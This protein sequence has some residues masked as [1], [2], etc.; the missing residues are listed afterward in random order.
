[1][2]PYASQ[3][4]VCMNHVFGCMRVFVPVQEQLL[5][6]EETEKQRVLAT[7]SKSRFDLNNL[8][9]E[10]RRLVCTAV[11]WHDFVGACSC[12]MV[13]RN[14]GLERVQKRA[15]ADPEKNIEA[16]IIKVLMTNFQVL[17]LAA[18]FK[19]SWP[20]WLLVSTRPQWTILSDLCECSR[21]SC[22]CVP[23]STC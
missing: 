6:V 7:K 11:V 8:K 17:G 15:V 22:R 2:K 12:L 21:A 10:H 9:I 23:A 1:M 14:S 3:K 16:A 19:L 18:S 20:T 13:V 5:A 4:H